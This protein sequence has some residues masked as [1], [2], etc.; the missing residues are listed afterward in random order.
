M[1]VDTFPKILQQDIKASHVCSVRCAWEK[2]SSL[3]ENYISAE[4]VH[5]QLHLPFIDTLF[6]P[7]ALD[8]NPVTCHNS[9]LTSDHV[10][11]VSCNLPLKKFVA[12]Q[13]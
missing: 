13:V 9:C 5:L 8:V 4:A 12:Y 6:C 2:L 10:I 7:V 1:E 3:L 11:I